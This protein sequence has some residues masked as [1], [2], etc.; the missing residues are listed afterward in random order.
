M[1]VTF[2]FYNALANDRVY[3]AIQLSSMFDGIIEDG[4][5]MSYADSLFVVENTGMLITVGEGR[6]WFDHTWTLNDADLVLTVPASEV[7]LSRID[8]VVIEVN[9]DPGVRTNAIKIIAGTPSS[10]PVAPTLVNSGYLH[11]Y[12]LAYIAVAPGVTSITQSDITN[13]VGTGECPFVT[14]VVEGMD[15]DAL[16]LQWGSQWTDWTEEQQT[17]FD[18][19]FENVMDQLSTEAAGNLQLQIN[20]AVSDITAIE[21]VNTTQQAAL[22]AIASAIQEVEFVVIDY[23][24]SCLVKDGVHYF[25]IPTKYNGMNLVSYVARVITAGTTGDMLIQIHNVTT[26]VDIFS[27][28]ITIASGAL[29][30]SAGTINT[31]NDHM[32]TGNLLRVDIDQLH[33]TPAKGLIL[34][35]GFQ[36]P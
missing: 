25:L 33:T 5:F 4:V 23:E 8:A 11:Q 29:V 24:T 13:K 9:A 27:T 19:W 16:I 36:V 12:P 10:T 7:V 1:A 22:N 28:R 3:D 21:G 30:A 26:A 14:G 18:E 17:A 20:A 34:I 2:G 6:A 35:L 32:A 15:I 31:S